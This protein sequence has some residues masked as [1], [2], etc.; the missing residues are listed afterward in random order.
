MALA[1]RMG[2]QPTPPA[3][4]TRTGPSAVGQAGGR[5]SRLGERRR[6]GGHAAPSMARR[7]AGERDRA[8][9]FKRARL[10]RSH[11]LSARRPPSPEHLEDAF[12]PRPDRE[13]ECGRGASVFFVATHSPVLCVLRETTVAF[14]RLVSQKPPPS[15]LSLSP[16]PLLPHPA[17][18]RASNSRRARPPPPSASPPLAP[19]VTVADPCCSTPRATMHM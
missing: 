3:C 12:Q 4:M 14:L 9:L 7:G 1:A 15:P 5:G 19:T 11:G 13:G 8:L 10:L 16:S 18:S 6:R 2:A 17:A